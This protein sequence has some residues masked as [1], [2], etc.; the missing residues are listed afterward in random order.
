MTIIDEIKLQYKTGGVIEKL[1]YWNV[2]LF[3]VPFLFV[4]VSSLFGVS[5]YFTNLISLSSNPADLLWKPWSIISYAF[6]HS[7]FLHLLFNLI[8]FYFSGRLFLT[9]FTQ[10]QLLGLYLLGG[11]FAG[12]FYLISYLIFP[13]LVQQQAQLIGASGAIMATMFGVATYA[14]RM[15]VRLL[16][17]GSVQLWQ[18][19]AVYL[20]VDL[21]SLSTANTGG[22]LAHLG[23]AVFGF[24]FSS[25]LKKGRDITQWFSA[26]IAFFVGLFSVKKATPFKKVHKNKLAVKPT[27]A[28][29]DKTQQQI[30]EILDKISKSGYDSLTKE[31]KEFLFKAGN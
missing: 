31:E 10:K 8:V 22:H 5:F 23:G 17:L 25:Q 3:V 1:L 20:I 13:A 16:L 19:A 28:A 29:K 15:Q 12:I 18:I 21:I 9:L 6:F 4:G 14:P 30:D 11:V 2:A 27:P 7:G 26:S 24:V